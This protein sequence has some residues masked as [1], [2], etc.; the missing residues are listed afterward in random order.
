MATIT[1]EVPDEL[2]LRLQSV[3]ANLPNFLNYALDLAG[4]PRNSVLREVSSPW[5]EALEFLAGAPAPDEII[6]YKMS[7]QAQERLEELLDLNRE[8]NLTPQEEDELDAFLQIDHLF[9][10]LKAHVR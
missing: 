6:A 4:I 5:N 7:E 1:L 3:G 10:M 8:G 2:A 9:I